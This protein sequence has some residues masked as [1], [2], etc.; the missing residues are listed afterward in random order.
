MPAYSGRGFGY[1]EGEAGE[2]ATD[3]DWE[4]LKTHLVPCG[5]IWKKTGDVTG[6]LIAGFPCGVG[7]PSWAQARVIG[8]LDSSK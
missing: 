3:G 4:G 5:W 8:S 2:N 6:A 7:F 1:A